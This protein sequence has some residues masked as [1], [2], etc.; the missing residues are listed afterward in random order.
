MTQAPG[1]KAYLMERYDTDGIVKVLF[2]LHE[3]PNGDV[4]WA[5]R[6]L[7]PDVTIDLALGLHYYW[8]AAGSS[9]VS[10]GDLE[11]FMALTDHDADPHRF[12][13]SALGGYD[14]DEGTA[15]S[16][17][18]S[19]FVGIA[20]M[21]QY[22]DVTWFHPLPKKGKA[23]I[24]SPRGDMMISRITSGRAWPDYLAA[25]HRSSSGN[26]DDQRVYALEFKGRERHVDFSHK[27]FQ[28]WVEQSRNIRVLDAD[29]VA[30]QVEAWVLAFNYRCSASSSPHTAS[31]LLA[32][33]PWVGPLDAP[34]FRG[35]TGIARLHL[36][37]QVRNL[38]F[39]WLSP[40][41]L[42]GRP[43]R[44]RAAFPPTFLIR[45]P[46]C[47]GRH[48]IGRFLQ[49]GPDG[50][51]H[52]TS[53]PTSAGL[54]TLGDVHI[55][56]KHGD[57]NQDTI[58]HAWR[59]GTNCRVDVHIDGQALRLIDPLLDWLTSTPGDDREV[60]FVGQD[61]EMVSHCMRTPADEELRGDGFG[62][63]TEFQDFGGGGEFVSVIRNGSVIASQQLVEPADGRSE[64]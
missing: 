58:V 56:L 46:K 59:D 30:Q 19:K 45:H 5:I 17:R 42:N 26:M 62:R 13:G 33:D 29:R 4:P 12:L 6:E 24:P 53:P 27:A 10:Y 41:V 36:S 49:M 3:E 31:T 48:Y 43:L 20:F 47:A 2:K 28:A 40:S 37:R 14:E 16:G 57:G 34:V 52:V 7:G 61:A 8:T 38:G 23:V 11:T 60:L 18:L 55:E 54:K 1:S 35:G 9:V 51:W 64:R 21:A 50:R 44:G 25:Q 32:Y 22:G 39:P 15:L 63:A